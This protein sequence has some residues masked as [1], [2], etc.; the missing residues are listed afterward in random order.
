[1]PL[2]VARYDS[3]GRLLWVTPLPYDR[4]ISFELHVDG[5]TALVWAQEQRVMNHLDRISG[6]LVRQDTLLKSFVP[7]TGLSYPSYKPGIG[8]FVNTFDGITFLDRNGTVT[9][10][11]DPEVHQYL[12][13]FTRDPL[14]RWYVSWSTGE[15]DVYSPERVFLQPILVGAQNDL[16]FRRGG[17]YAQPF[18]GSNLVRIT[19][20][21]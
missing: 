20:G 5:D 10:R 9:S 15:L 11:W 19:T 6:R 17:L 12:R 4:D 2:R 7:P 13:D 14:G 3:T 8:F 16:A 21:L 18:P 1:M